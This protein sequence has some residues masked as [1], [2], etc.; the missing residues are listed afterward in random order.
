MYF[1]KDFIFNANHTCAHISTLLR[2]DMCLRTEVNLFSDSFWSAMALE[3]S[4]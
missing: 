1:R 2:N 3:L 4:P